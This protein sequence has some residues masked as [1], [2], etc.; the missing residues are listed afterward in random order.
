MAGLLNKTQAIEEKLLILE[1]LF[2]FETETARPR[3]QGKPF[4]EA[5]A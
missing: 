5:R 3:V 1:Q 4:I 2:G